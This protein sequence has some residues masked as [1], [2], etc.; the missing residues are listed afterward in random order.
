MLSTPEPE[1]TSDSEDEGWTTMTAEQ[2]EKY[3]N[4]SSGE[5][6]STHE[7][8]PSEQASAGP[9]P[10]E[11][12]KKPAKK[13][14]TRSLTPLP[15]PREQENLSESEYLFIANDSLNFQNKRRH[16]GPDFRKQVQKIFKLTDN[17]TQTVAIEDPTRSS[18]LCKANYSSEGHLCANIMKKINDGERIST[19]EAHFLE[20]NRNW[21]YSSVGQD[22]STL[23]L[24]D[25]KAI[26]TEEIEANNWVEIQVK[27]SP[28]D[29]IDCLTEH[30][31]R[32]FDCTK[33]NL[34]GPLSCE[35]SLPQIPYSS[36]MIGVQSY[37]NMPWVTVNS[38]LNFSLTEASDYDWETTVPWDEELESQSTPLGRAVMK[39]MNVFKFEH[40]LPMFIEFCWEKVKTEKPFIVVIFN[41]LRVVKSLQKLHQPPIIALMSLATPHRKH[42]TNSYLNLKREVIRKSCVARLLGIIM[43]VPFME[44][45]IQRRPSFTGD[46]FQW[47]KSDTWNMEPLFN[48]N[49]Q[50]TGEMMQRMGND[51]LWI[52]RHLTGVTI[53]HTLTPYETEE[54]N[55]PWCE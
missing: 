39:R 31:Y 12:P 10:R 17:L 38:I 54:E 14:V 48:R 42:T 27:R 5:E 22:L 45:P 16:F 34:N 21:Y 23:L 37:L 36:I 26:R 29:C 18:V 11:Q 49:I 47:N 33:R 52:T 9:V 28:Q 51:L 30:K 35:L 32:G 7:P 50:F 20:H 55:E 6:E 1:L 3:I 40:R 15:F 24:M 13:S 8:G 25:F 44:L 46:M 43:G 41:F 53:P 2:Y 19:R 4:S